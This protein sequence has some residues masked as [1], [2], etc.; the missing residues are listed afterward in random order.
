MK[1]TPGTIRPLRSQYPYGAF[2]KRPPRMFVESIAA[3]ILS[4]PVDMF[5]FPNFL[6]VSRIDI[7]EPCFVFFITHNN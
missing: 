1:T 4:A 2:A 6:A 5:H 7:Q 3:D